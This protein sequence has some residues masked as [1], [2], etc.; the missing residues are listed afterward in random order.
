MSAANPANEA[1]SIYIT[2]EVGLSVFLHAESLL[3]S[4]TYTL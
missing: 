3:T 4:A 1:E 2:P